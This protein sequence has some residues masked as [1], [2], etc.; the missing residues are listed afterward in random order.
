MG[1]LREPTLDPKRGDTE[2]SNSA[3]ELGW[4]RLVH[5]CPHWPLAGLV[6]NMEKPSD[7]QSPQ[8]N[9]EDTA[10]IQ[11]HAQ[12]IA[13]LP[14]TDSHTQS[15]TRTC[16]TETYTTTDAE[17]TDRACTH[18]HAHTHTDSCRHMAGPTWPSQMHSDRTTHDTCAH[19]DTH[20]LSVGF[21]QFHSITVKI[22]FRLFS[23]SEEEERKVEVKNIS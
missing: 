17:T 21:L 22:S 7:T 13:T 16:S 19:T 3:W 14:P 10:D 11:S 4:P 8:N 12:Q 5:S 2:G 18:A 1:A 23:G 9:N 15:H 20:T 6:N